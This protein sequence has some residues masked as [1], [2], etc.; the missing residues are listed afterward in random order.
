MHIN[1]YY[2]VFHFEV[3]SQSHV[4]LVPMTLGYRLQHFAN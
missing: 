1:I 4:G 2:K 3:L